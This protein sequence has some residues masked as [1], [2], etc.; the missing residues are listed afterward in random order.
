M[1]QPRAGKA[2]RQGRGAGAGPAGGRCRRLALSCPA[3]RGLE[4]GRT[5]VCRGARPVDPAAAVKFIGACYLSLKA[6]PC[7]EFPRGSCFSFP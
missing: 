4:G 6:V 5:G 2:G 1:G 7:L 3:V